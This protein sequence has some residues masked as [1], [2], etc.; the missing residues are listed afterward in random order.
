MDFFY[1]GTGSPAGGLNNAYLKFKYT[2]GPNL[3]FMADYHSFALNK[4]MKKGDGSTLD[5][6]LGSEV[7]LILNANLNKFTNLEFGY[8]VMAASN[9]LSIAKAQVQTVIYNKTGTWAY[10]MLNIRPDFFYAKPVAIK[11]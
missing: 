1:V 8:S 9:S 2:V 10:L 3:Y 11:Q 6:S 7:D 4:P 5:S